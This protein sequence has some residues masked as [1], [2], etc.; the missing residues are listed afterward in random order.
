[1][2]LEEGDGQKC[3]LDNVGSNNLPP[4]WKAVFKLLLRPSQKSYELCDGT[5]RCWHEFEETES[6]NTDNPV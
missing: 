2:R 6:E 1:M 4:L 3:V 5:V